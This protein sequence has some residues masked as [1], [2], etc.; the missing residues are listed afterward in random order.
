MATALRRS[1][2]WA[3]MNAR[4]GSQA[5][6]VGATAVGITAGVIAGAG[7]GAG[8]QDGGICCASAAATPGEPVA[9]PGEFA[10]AAAANHLW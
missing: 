10:A 9:T 2:S 1:R 4:W 8:G 7:A 3:S 5:D 6:A